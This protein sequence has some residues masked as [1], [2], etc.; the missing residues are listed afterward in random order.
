MLAISLQKKIKKKPF[1]KK[2]IQPLPVTNDFAFSKW[3]AVI[4]KL[5]SSEA[6]TKCTRDIQ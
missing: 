1:S 3:C 2:L 4:Q 6:F 5:E